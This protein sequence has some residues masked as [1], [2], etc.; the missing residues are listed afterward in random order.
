MRNR[1]VSTATTIAILAL[2]AACG[3]DDADPPV[4]TPAA[5]TA[6]A[7]PAP[8]D[9][10][11]TGQPADGRA[12]TENVAR[13][14]ADT[15]NSGDEAGVAALFAPDARF[16]SVGRIYPSRD[17]IMSRFL[18]PEVLRVDGR[19]EP[20]EERWDGTR[21]TVTYR[22][23]TGSGGEERFT[24]AYLVRDGLIQDVIGRYL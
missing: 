14:F 11:G 1:L 17:E 13:R 15:A 7:G 4:G 21:L 12:A 16:D 5:P 20:G 18:V 3:S 9:S 2:V 6:S 8:V 22:F 10:T 23:T 24:Y 19:Y